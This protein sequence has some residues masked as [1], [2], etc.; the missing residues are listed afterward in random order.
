[1]YGGMQVCVVSFVLL[2]VIQPFVLLLLDTFPV[3]LPAAQHT[4]SVC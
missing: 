2:S 1:M 4:S 3:L